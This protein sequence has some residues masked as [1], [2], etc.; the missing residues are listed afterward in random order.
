MDVNIVKKNETDYMGLVVKYHNS[1]SKNNLHLIYEGE[2][3]QT[4][5]KAFISLAEKNMNELKERRKTVRKVYHVMVE[6]LQNIFK[7]ADHQEEGDE[8]VRNKGIF[9]MG[10]EKDGYAILTGNMVDND[11]LPKL[12]KLLESVNLMSSEE[13][14][15]F[16]QT[17]IRK[18]GLSDKGGAGLGFVDIVRRTGHKLE[19]R[20]ENINEKSTFF[21]LK[22]YIAK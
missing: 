16:Y 18:E 7:H 9:L 5:T 22:T 19:Y 13:L 21:I 10:K 4:I 1:M 8:S 17:R 6:F 3:D 20:F 2:V 11:K 12:K 15:E 14:K